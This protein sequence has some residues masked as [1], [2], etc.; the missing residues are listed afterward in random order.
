MRSL[1]LGIVVILTFIATA[2]CLEDLQLKH[3]KFEEKGKRELFRIKNDGN[4]QDPYVWGED[5][6]P[7]V[8]KDMK[9][10]QDEKK[11]L[12]EFKVTAYKSSQ[13]E[14]FLAYMSIFRMMQNFLKSKGVRPEDYTNKTLIRQFCREYEP[15][16][17]HADQL[18]LLIEFFSTIAGHDN[19]SEH[20]FFGVAGG[21]RMD[22]NDIRTEKIDAP[23]NYLDS[24]SIIGL[25]KVSVD[26]KIGYVLVDMEYPGKETP[27]VME[28][29]PI[30]AGFKL[31]A[32]YP[33]KDVTPVKYHLFGKNN[34]FIG[35]VQ[36]KYNEIQK[37]FSP[38]KE[39]VIY[40]GKPLCSF[41]ETHV[42]RTLLYTKTLSVIKY[43]G[44]GKEYVTD[45]FIHAQI[46][47]WDV[48]KRIELGYRWKDEGKTVY[49]QLFVD[50]LDSIEK[51]SNFT[52]VYDKAVERFDL[53]KSYMNQ[54]ILKEFEKF[55][56][57]DYVAPPATQNPSKGFK[58]I[59][60]WRNK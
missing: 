31:N 36:F 40:V 18:V 22:V 10:L 2:S 4:L 1:G 46:A 56:D 9:H 15:E 23:R 60:N 47:P 45:A 35:V 41:V 14:N 5:I 59:F 26:N 12:D 37:E 24:E 6:S 52:E 25:I 17:I 57:K 48:S 30:P 42:R 44:D 20:L 32:E 13:F 58:I 49:T 28:D 55:I 8:F 54:N 34:A 33:S 3:C 43:F 29:D 7:L 16:K 53:S 51:N 50:N 11:R 39:D 19:L 38:H 27:I 21:T